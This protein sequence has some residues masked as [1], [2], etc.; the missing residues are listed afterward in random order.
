M[1]NDL[2]VMRKKKKKNDEEEEE[3]EKKKT[4]HDVIFKAI[5]RVLMNRANKRRQRHNSTT[6][7]DADVN[8]SNLCVCVAWG[9]RWGN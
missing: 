1:A 8:V 6:T 4:T 2:F 7:L 9:G 3:E 5:D